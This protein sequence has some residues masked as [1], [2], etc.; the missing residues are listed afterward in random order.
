MVLAVIPTLGA[1]ALGQGVSAGLAPSQAQFKIKPGDLLRAALEI[2]ALS[3][4]GQVPVAS[5]DP[6]SGNLVVST[7]DQ[8]QNLFGILSDRADRL[9]LPFTEEDTGALFAARE[10]FIDAAAATAR[11]TSA[12]RGVNAPSFTNRV[13][14]RP[15]P[16]G[17]VARGGIPSASAS[18]TSRLS[19]PC[20]GPQTGISRLRCGGI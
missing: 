14:A 15:A 5:T 8:A 6:F 20:A 13:T 9:D 1:A 7:A 4:R 12:L 10:R 3:E 2:Q 16:G 19:S 18:R 11:P 17:G